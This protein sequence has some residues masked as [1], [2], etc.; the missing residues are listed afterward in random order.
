MILTF[1]GEAVILFRLVTKR[2]LWIV[3][4]SRERIFM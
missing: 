1:L 4:W 2:Y 3:E